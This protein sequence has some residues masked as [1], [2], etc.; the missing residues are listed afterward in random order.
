[1]NAFCNGPRKLGTM[2][3]MNKTQYK[4]D[5]SEE[6]DPNSRSVG[7]SF[8]FN[9]NRQKQSEFIIHMVL[10]VTLHRSLVSYKVL[11]AT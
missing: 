11:L 1:M 6:R 8:S 7:G 3:F 9:E 5:E 10:S 4:S 2:Y